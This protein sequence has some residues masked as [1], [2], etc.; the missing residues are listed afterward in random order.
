MATLIAGRLLERSGRKAGTVLYGVVARSI[1][2]H[3]PAEITA[4]TNMVGLS[5]IFTGS[6]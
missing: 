4:G 1:Y 2:S 3:A 6:K 5:V